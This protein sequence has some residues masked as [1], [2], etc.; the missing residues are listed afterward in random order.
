MTKSM[1]PV[2]WEVARNTIGAFVVPDGLQMAGTANPSCI[3]AM[4]TV[5]VQTTGIS[6]R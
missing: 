2:S 4:F 1:F 6:G 3:G 5:P